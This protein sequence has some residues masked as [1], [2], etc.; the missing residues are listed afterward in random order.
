MILLSV[1]VFAVYNTVLTYP[2]VDADVVLVEGF[3]LLIEWL[4]ISK[5]YMIDNLYDGKTPVVLLFM[6]YISL[7]EYALL[8]DNID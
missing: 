7:S 4:V 2:T 5:S 3:K 6:S 1:Y 8:Y